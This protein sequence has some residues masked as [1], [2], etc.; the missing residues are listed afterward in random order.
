MITPTDSVQPSFDAAWTVAMNLA[1]EGF[2]AGTTPVGAVVV[3][4]D[5]S[6]VAVGRGR[7][8]EAT[9]PDRQLAGS[10]IAHGEVNALAQL[11]TERHWEDHVLLTTLE[12]CGMCH[13]AA[14][15]ATV[16]Q[17][18]YAAPDPYGGTAAVRFGTPQS[19]RRPLIVRGPLG[20]QRGAFAT[21]LHIVWLMQRPSASH[22]VDL[23]DS[24]LPS[25][26]SFARHVAKDLQ[27]AAAMADY[28]AALQIASD[29]PVAEL[30]PAR[31]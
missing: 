9:A 21:L 29:A 4:P 19:H 2:G 30:A 22:V 8:Y 10:Q 23:H 3:G 12:P 16:G 25:I 18:H 7:R 6:I 5:A 31:S 15:Q 14:V 26:T 27:R 13:G 28:D 17:L 20:D 24:L 11:G 1:W